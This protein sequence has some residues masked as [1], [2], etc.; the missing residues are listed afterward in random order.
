M[1][2]LFIYKKYNSRSIFGK[3]KKLRA[4]RTK[5]SQN[6]PV[7]TEEERKEVKGLST[8]RTLLPV[9]FPFYNSRS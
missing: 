9:L 2:L 8:K 5:S 3:E 7:N 6:T 1:P 4:R